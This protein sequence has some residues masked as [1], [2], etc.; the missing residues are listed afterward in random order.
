MNNRA[1]PE[2]EDSARVPCSWTLLIAGE[3]THS[4]LLVQITL[5]KRKPG[6]FH[7][8][9]GSVTLFHEQLPDDYEQHLL[10]MALVVFFM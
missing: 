2:P 9:T 6:R 3:N 4:P 8:L 1:V 10:S 7:L 5:F